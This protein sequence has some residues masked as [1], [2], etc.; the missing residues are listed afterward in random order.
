MSDDDDNDNGIR[1]GVCKWISQLREHGSRLAE[2]K[3]IN[4]ATG[5]QKQR[6]QKY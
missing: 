6:Q 4:I 2:R 5:K 3:N 1:V